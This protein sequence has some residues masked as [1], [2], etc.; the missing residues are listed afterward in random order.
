MFKK[1][2]GSS[3]A[4]APVDEPV[5]DD[6]A[7]GR[8]LRAK[9][10]FEV[11]DIPECPA[12]PAVVKKLYRRLALKVHPDKNPGDTRAEK[13]FKILAAAHEVLAD[14]RQQRDLLG[15]VRDQK[16]DDL[17]SSVRKTK[18]A[19]EARYEAEAD[20]LRQRRDEEARLA[21]IDA[22]L[23]KEHKQTEK[24]NKERRQRERDA[25]A[26][27]AALAAARHAEEEERLD[28]DRRRREKKELQRARRRLRAAA[29]ALAE[30]AE[31]ED[32]ALSGGMMTHDEIEDLCAWL[33]V[34]RIEDA[35]RHILCDG[36][37]EKVILIHDAAAAGI[38]AAAALEHLDLLERTGAL[39]AKTAADDALR[40]LEASWTDAET[41]ALIRMA[42][43]HGAPPP[44]TC[45]RAGAAH[46]STAQ[47]AWAAV[48]D[49]H[50]RSLRLDRLRTAEECRLRFRAVVKAIVEEERVAKLAATKTTPRAAAAMAAS[51]PK[52]PPAAAAG[53]APTPA[54]EWS[55]DDQLRFES[56]LAANPASPDQDAKARWRTIAACL[57]DKTPKQCLARYK[58]IAA[59]VKASRS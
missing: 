34:S 51:L 55:R 21:R 58:Q 41:S 53:A 5:A 43:K 35:T 4:R 13:A 47:I 10:A 20:A 46:P 2:W 19:E 18:M 56:A 39:A 38:A 15:L 36:S 24:A 26:R 23:R 27:E 3:A 48:A 29:A 31:E 28:K 6:D 49:Q 8:I 11:L 7:I 54:D 16:R 37:F 22:D 12:A 59:M 32:E 45:A 57:G 50:N 1:L 33:E 14:E 40:R 30:D 9:N 44:E 17:A 42:K 52:P 25:A